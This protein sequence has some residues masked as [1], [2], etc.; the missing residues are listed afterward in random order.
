VAMLLG[1]LNSVAQAQTP[2]ELS[3][4]SADRTALRISYRDQEGLLPRCL[5]SGLAGRIRYELVLCRR[6]ESWF[7]GC[8]ERHTHIRTVLANAIS[9]SYLLSDDRFGDGVD[10]REQAYDDR[11]AGLR[12]LTTLEPVE[13]S[14]LGW[15]RGGGRYYVSVRALVDCKGE[16]N[17]HLARIPYILTLGL[18]RLNGANS[19]WFDFSLE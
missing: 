16:Y 19:G 14:S 1:G 10:P 4:A 2:L 15:R 13:L 18:I 6:R 9:E 3:W 11:T 12:A 5:E 7:D 8:G 17:R